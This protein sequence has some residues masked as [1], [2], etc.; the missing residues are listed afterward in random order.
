MEQNLTYTKRLNQIS[1]NKKLWLGLKLFL[2]VA[3][4]LALT[5]LFSYFPLYGWVYSFY[6]FKPPLKLA[7]SPFVG[8]HWFKVLISSPA[9]I[10]QIIEVMRNTF[11][12]SGISILTSWMPMAFAIFL[13]EIKAI[14]VK[15][16]IQIFTTLPNFISWVMVYSLAYALFSSSGMYNQLLMSLGLTDKPILFL[17]SSRN[18]WISMGLWQIW[19]GLG[20]GAILYLASIAGIDPQ[21]YEAAEIDGAGR[22]R[23]MWHIT[24]PGLLPTYIVLLLLNIASLLNNGMEQFYV[25]QNAFN[26]SHIQVLDLYV[27]NLGIGSGSYSMATVISMLKS[28]VS[29]SLLLAVNRLSKTLRGE[30]IV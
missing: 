22:F 15:K 9:Q 7:Q 3:P 26:I 25:F 28:I 16:S 14:K 11:A 19:K 29:V 2:M 13:S 1:K 24:L 21:L 18:T 4:F 20:W 5:F 12:M 30:T 6:D 8:F 27:Y 10:K 17:S 23:L